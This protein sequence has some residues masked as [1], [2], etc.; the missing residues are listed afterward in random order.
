MRVTHPH[1]L[2]PKIASQ[3]ENEYWEI[4]NQLAS[5]CAPFL[6][7]KLSS[8]YLILNPEILQRIPLKSPL[9]GT[10]GV[11]ERCRYN[12]ISVSSL[13]LFLG[14]TQLRFRHLL[15]YHSGPKKYLQLVCCKPSLALSSGVRPRDFPPLQSI[16]SS[17]SFPQWAAEAGEV[18]WQQP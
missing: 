2:R 13:L 10:A 18:G 15:Y 3:V 4:Q 5:I 14:H 11:A 7:S 12:Y 6:S 1:S 9:V 17:Q 8:L 16:C